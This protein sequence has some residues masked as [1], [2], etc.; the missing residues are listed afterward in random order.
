MVPLHFHSTS[1]QQFLLL[2][3][4]FTKAVFTSPTF[5]SPWRSFSL[6]SLAD[7]FTSCLTTSL[8]PTPLHEMCHPCHLIQISSSEN[9]NHQHKGKL[10]HTMCTLFPSS[11][12][13][14]ITEHKNLTQPP[15]APATSVPPFMEEPQIYVSYLQTFSAQCLK[16]T[17]THIPLHSCLTG[18]CF[19]V[20]F[21]STIL[22]HHHLTKD[23]FSQPAPL[24]TPSLSPPHLPPPIPLPPI[25]APV[26]F[27][28]RVT[29][30]TALSASAHD[31]HLQIH[32]AVLLHA[33]V[34]HNKAF[35]KKEIFALHGFSP[36]PER[37]LFQFPNFKDEPKPACKGCGANWSCIFKSTA[38]H[39]PHAPSSLSTITARE[40][41][42]HGM[43]PSAQGKKKQ[44]APCHLQD[45]A[46][47]S[48]QETWYYTLP[49]AHKPAG[50][51]AALH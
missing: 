5:S 14:F 17:N 11:P 10:S 48:S 39:A 36:H 16:P 33:A 37:N 4:S 49:A 20:A 25:P 41:G 43:P 9:L 21:L 8:R 26:T 24:K 38:Q 19:S 2:W 32:A 30:L 12:K 22:P 44:L 28:I 45:K 27:S 42:I 3:L 47:Q 1:T 50:R 18:L 7:K 15:L 35:K 6:H 29:S 51:Q 13:F 34:V 31:K 40:A 46:A 23:I